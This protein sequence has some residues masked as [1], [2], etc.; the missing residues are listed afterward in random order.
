[1]SLTSA[2][3]S[4]LIKQERL[5][6]DEE[7]EDDGESKPRSYRLG[8]APTRV[9]LRSTLPVLFVSLR[10]MLDRHTGARTD[11]R[12][13][14]AQSR[15]MRDRGR[16]GRPGLAIPIH[17]GVFLPHHSG[18]ILDSCTALLLHVHVQQFAPAAL[19]YFGVTFG[20]ST[21]EILRAN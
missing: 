17:M 3:S 11:V 4:L 7:E 9:P 20:V 12:I 2:S 15:T 14:G 16:H 18:L 5:A 10:R 13:I 19:P 1:M 6:K 21:L 8:R